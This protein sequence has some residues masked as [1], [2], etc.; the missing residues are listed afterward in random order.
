MEQEGPPRPTHYL[1]SADTETQEGSVTFSGS[2]SQLVTT[3]GLKPSCPD[4]VPWTGNVRAW[5]P[6]AEGWSLWVSGELTRSLLIVQK[7]TWA[8][9]V[10]GGAQIWIWV[11]SGESSS[12]YLQNQH[13]NPKTASLSKGDFPA[14]SMFWIDGIMDLCPVTQ[15]LGTLFLYLR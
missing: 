7:V 9:L 13:I 1:K 10:S 6:D 4:S 11:F 5:G 2:S 3:P 15:H 8:Q 14:K 12:Y